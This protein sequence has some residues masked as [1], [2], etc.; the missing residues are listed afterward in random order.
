MIMSMIEEMSNQVGK[1]NEVNEENK[2][3]YES[4][5][6]ELERY[7]EQIKFFEERQKFD[8]ND[9][10]K[11]IDGQLR[12]VI[13]D[14][15]AK[16]AYFQNQ[17]HTLKLQLSAT[18]ESHKNLSTTIDVLKKESKAKEDKYLEEIIDLEK[19]KKALDNVV[20]K[21][22]QSTQTM[23]MLTKP[24]VFYDESHKTTLG[25][26]KPSNS[27]QTKVTSLYCGH[28]IVKLHDTLFVMDIEETLILAEESRL[29]MH[30]KQND[31]ISKDKKV[32]I[33]PIDY[34]ALNKL[35]EH[36]VPQKQLFVEQ[37]FWLPISHPVSK[38]LPVQPKPV[39]KE[40]HGELPIISLVKDSCNKMR[41]H[42][43]KFDEVITVRTKVT[44]QN[45]GTWGFEHIRK[46]YEK[47]VKPFVKL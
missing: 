41:S 12:E 2:T 10:E 43:N 13:F 45:K 1:C 17:I 18:V 16:V 20:Y 14:R 44:G 4:L 24:Q 9:K 37:A 3:V 46:A 32:N 7:K 35:F 30:A 29:K 11:Y 19:K 31:P 23:H 8:L 38:T 21:M 26:Q 27:S 34:A 28:T 39:L 40:I 5:T 22:G 6:D 33:A 25:Y 15:N 47:D 36:F 42:V